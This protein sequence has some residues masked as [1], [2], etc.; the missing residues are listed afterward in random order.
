MLKERVSVILAL[1]AG[2]YQEQNA[3]KLTLQNSICV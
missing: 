2:V 1:L 3:H